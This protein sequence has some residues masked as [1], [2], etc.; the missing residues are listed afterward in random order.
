MTLLAP[1]LSSGAGGG[2]SVPLPF[3]G[4][5]ATPFVRLPISRISQNK[6]AYINKAQLG[7]EDGITLGWT[8]KVHPAFCDRDDM[9]EPLYNMMGE[10]CKCLQYALFPKTSKYKRSKDGDKMTMNG[11]TLQL[12]K[13]PGITASDFRA[14]MAERWLKNGNK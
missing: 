11:I 7:K 2:V 14:D 1:R 8:L 6:R 5:P 12:A 9:K 4:C 3:P 13:T 10:V